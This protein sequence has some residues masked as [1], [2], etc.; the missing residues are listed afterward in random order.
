MKNII[1]EFEQD[2]A[3]LFSQYAQTAFPQIIESFVQNGLNEYDAI[4]TL[5]KRHLS[6]LSQ[7]GEIEYFIFSWYDDDNFKHIITNRKEEK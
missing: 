5:L 4:K 2:G 1:L 6:A 7:S 3:I